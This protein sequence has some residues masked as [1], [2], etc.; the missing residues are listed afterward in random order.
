MYAQN[1]QTT[2]EDSNIDEGRESSFLNPAMHILWLIF[3]SFQ[4]PP[5][6]KKSAPSATG[7]MRIPSLDRCHIKITARNA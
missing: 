3:S 7:N 5:A 6:S 2:K 4:V 1:A